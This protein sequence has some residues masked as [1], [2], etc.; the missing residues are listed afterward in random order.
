MSRQRLLPDTTESPRPSSFPS[1]PSSPPSSSRSSS[2]RPQ[3]GQG[4]L[5]PS[6]SHCP[7]LPPRLEA[8]SQLKGLAF[9][10][11]CSIPR[12]REHHSGG[13]PTRPPCKKGPG[14]HT[15]AC[16]LRHWVRWAPCLPPSLLILNNNINKSKWLPWRSGQPCSQPRISCVQGWF[17][18][19]RGQEGGAAGRWGAGRERS[20]SPSPPG[21][22]AR[23]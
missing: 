3:A 20:P 7:A 1:L 5:S 18:R 12:E 19:G 17:G 21:G 10:R 6:G 9:S 16:A 15:A 14:W 23:S 8:W 11:N 2:S 22:L 4:P 13:P